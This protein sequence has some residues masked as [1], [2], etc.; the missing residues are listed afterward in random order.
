MN[1]NL[2]EMKITI[3]FALLHLYLLLITV[4]F[5]KYVL[6]IFIQGECYIPVGIKIMI[7]ICVF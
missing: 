1:E 7:F 3:R 4:S 6:F 2:Y 5:L